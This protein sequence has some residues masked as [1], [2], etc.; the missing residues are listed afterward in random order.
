MSSAIHWEKVSIIESD[1]NG[2]RDPGYNGIKFKLEA[3][4]K[5]SQIYRLLVLSSDWLAVGEK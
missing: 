1:R 4:E 3:Y 5:V 2:R